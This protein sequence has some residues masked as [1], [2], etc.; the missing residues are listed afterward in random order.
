MQ[1][2]LYSFGCRY[3]SK[4]D[5]FMCGSCKAV[6]ALGKGRIGA[7]VQHYLTDRHAK[8]Y[9]DEAEQIRRRRA[10]SDA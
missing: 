1:E 4:N 5:K 7:A 10:C 8:R 2:L 9:K 3:D 6:C